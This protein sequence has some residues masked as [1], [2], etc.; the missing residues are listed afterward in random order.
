MGKPKSPEH[1]AKIA[2]A[3]KGKVRPEEHCKNL[4]I[5][6]KGKPGRPMSEKTKTTL[7]KINLGRKHSEESKRKISEKKKGKPGKRGYLLSEERKRR[8]RETNLGKKASEE[9]KCK[10]SAS[11]KGL[12]RPP[13][14]EEH[15]RK[16]SEAHKGKKMSEQMKAKVSAL[17]K[18]RKDSA[19]TRAKRSASMKRLYLETNMHA[20][21][22]A[23]IKKNFKGGKKECPNKY[24]V[25]VRDTLDQLFPNEYKFVGDG[26]FTLAGLN[27]DFVNVN[28]QKKII[29]VFGEI[30]HK[31][32][33]FKTPLP[34][35]RT[36]EGR[37]EMFSQYGYQTL[38]VW[39]NE[40]KNPEA[41]TQKLLN[42]HDVLESK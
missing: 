40:L 26:S 32:G 24:E 33:V 1:R 27:P 8:L 16:L 35:N 2:A 37:K 38:V 10:M 28:G 36:E 21:V 5:A 39:C 20:R 19:E 14:S 31:P 34:K 9:T 41:L 4:S 7:R 22:L 3:N 12:K 15:C 6:K 25:K 11:Q 29:E 30:F 17:H 13:R 42:F 23:G 18:G